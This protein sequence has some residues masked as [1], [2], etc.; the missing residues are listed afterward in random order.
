MDYNYREK[1]IVIVLNSKLEIGVALN[2]S[3]HLALA[4]GYYAENHMGRKY[5]VDASG[6]RHLGISKYPVIITKVKSGKLKTSLHK[7]KEQKDIL[8]VDFPSTM[9][10]T[11]HDDELA[12]ALSKQTAE[13]I[14]YYGYIMYG[15]TAA[16][17]EV[18]GRFS[19]WR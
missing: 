6:E 12:E 16:I 14:E 15:D 8:V 17:D 18:S 19:L 5:L 2:V 13:E 3:G 7:A 10:E 1:K 4:L 11:G 9:Y